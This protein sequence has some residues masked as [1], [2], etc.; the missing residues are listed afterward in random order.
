MERTNAE[1]IILFSFFPDKK[2]GQNGG[3]VRRKIFRDGFIGQF[4]HSR[5][6]GIGNVRGQK[7][8][9]PKKSERNF[10]LK[11]WT[12]NE[13]ELFSAEIVWSALFSALVRHAIYVYVSYIPCLEVSQTYSKSFFYLLFF[14][15]FVCGKSQETAAAK[16][17]CM[18]SPF[19]RLRL[20]F[21]FPFFSYIAYSRGKRTSYNGPSSIEGFFPVSPG[22][23]YAFGA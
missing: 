4:V 16:I 9:F 23:D 7:I 1:V 21:P 10:P 20:F 18:P 14:F 2:I 13:K 19:A 3:C 11:R 5:P 6:E 12:K 22:S 8:Q 15:F 17:N